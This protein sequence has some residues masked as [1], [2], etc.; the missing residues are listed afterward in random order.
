[1]CTLFRLFL[2]SEKEEIPAALLALVPAD[3][4]DGAVSRKAS[5]FPHPTDQAEV[6]GVPQKPDSSLLPHTVLSLLLPGSQGSPG[7]PRQSCVDSGT[8]DPIIPVA[9]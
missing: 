3:G 5:G 9:F 7:L 8:K 2:I 4:S 6:D 1:M